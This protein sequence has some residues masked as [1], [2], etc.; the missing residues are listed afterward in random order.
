M[1]VTTGGVLDVVGGAQPAAILANGT[2]NLTVAGLNL[3]G[4][5]TSA[6]LISGNAMTINSSGPVVLTG[7]T[8]VTAFALIDPTVAGDINLSASSLT[9]QGG[10]GSGAANSSSFLR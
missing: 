8:G 7:G 4:T 5:T 6:S 9:L 3:T 1:K 2:M 10:S